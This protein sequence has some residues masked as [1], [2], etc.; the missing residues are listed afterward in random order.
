MEEAGG[1]NWFEEEILVE[2]DSEDEE[3]EEEEEETRDGIPVI[4]ISKDMRKKL[5]QPWKNALILKF[6]GKRI[7]FPVF[8]RKLLRMW[9]PQGRLE[10]IDLGFKFFVA[11]FELE[12][13][14]MRVL[15]EGPW[16][17]FDRYVVLQRW[18]PNFDQANTKAEN[19]AVCVRL[20]GLSM[21]SFSEDIIK[22]ILY[23]VG[24]PLK[25][26]RTTAGVERGCFVR[27][28]I[29]IDLSKPLVSTVNIGSKIERIEFEGLH[30]ICFGCG[31]VSHLSN[32]CPK[33]PREQPQDKQPQNNSMYG[34]WMLVQ[35]KGKTRTVSKKKQAGSNRTSV[36]NRFTAI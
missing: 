16:K 33:K 13:D 5:I 22:H 34:P 2:S 12:K 32:D 29:E 11:R 14:C 8:K 18:K 9:V 27:A 6:P 31:E 17:V 25:L 15:F 26:D 23:Q 20:P 24:T 35:P 30:T 7:N 28:V 3:E 10:V 4:K 21:E 19:M 36:A 1:I